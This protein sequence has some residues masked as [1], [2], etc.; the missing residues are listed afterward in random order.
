MSIGILAQCA[1]KLHAEIE[2]HLRSGLLCFKQSREVLVEAKSK[3]KHGEWLE[4]LQ[5]NLKASH[6][7]ACAYIRIW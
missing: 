1:N 3:V 7:T 5:A 2:T 4:W 6:Q